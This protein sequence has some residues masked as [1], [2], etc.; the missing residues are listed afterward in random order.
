MQK[1]WFGA[2]AWSFFSQVLLCVSLQR[3]SHPF[4][5]FHDW[6]CGNIFRYQP[7]KWH[8]IITKSLLWIFNTMRIYSTSISTLTNIV[9]WILWK[10]VSLHYCYCFKIQKWKKRIFTHQLI[11]LLCFFP[12]ENLKNS[13]KF[14]KNERKK[15]FYEFK[16]I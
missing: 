1:D 12:T 16:I 15:L 4:F 8:Q 6:N 11:I 13:T 9:F 14:N 10:L 2:K 3:K 5:F 7:F